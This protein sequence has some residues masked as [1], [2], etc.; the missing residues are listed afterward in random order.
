MVESKTPFDLGYRM[1]AEWKEHEAT[2]LAWPKNKDSF[3]GE[4]LQEVEKTFLRIIEELSEN[5]RVELLVDDDAAERRVRELISSTKTNINNLNMHKIPTGDVW[6]R[7]FGPIFISRS[8]VHRRDVACTHWQ[9]NAWG[10]KYEEIKPDIHVAEK[11][12]IPGMRGFNVQMVLEGGSIETNG[13]GTI[14]TT[15]QCLLN[16]NRNPGLNK[17]QIENFLRNYLGAVKVIWLKAGIAGDDTDGHID[18]IA[19][20]VSHD[21]VVCAYED[22]P[23]DENYQALKADYDLINKSQDQDGN[24]LKVAKLPMPKRI[25]YNGQRLPASYTNFYVANEKVLVPTFNDENDQK[26]LDMLQKLFPDRKIVGIDCR[27]LVVGFG[28][29]HCVTQQQPA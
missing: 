25:E 4:I 14:I 20:F 23:Q 15:E 17:G 3:P 2:W 21:I 11:M 29:I 7:D 6:F 22:N 24:E 5:E 1:P 19:R 12:P 16:K 28:A 27:A 18:D 13:L 9:F 10:N 8:E 26:A